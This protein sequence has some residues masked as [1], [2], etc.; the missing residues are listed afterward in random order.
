VHGHYP[1]GSTGEFT[2]FTAE[3]GGGSCGLLVTKLGE[4]LVEGYQYFLTQA[5]KE[6]DTSAFA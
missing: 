2:C 4:S 6:L 3:S 1:N 5:R